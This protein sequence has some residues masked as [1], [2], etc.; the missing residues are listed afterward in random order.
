M[1]T[2]RA[3]R[4]VGIVEDL[5]GELADRRMALDGLVLER[6]ILE[7]LHDFVDLLTDLIRRGAG[8]GGD[9]GGDDES[10]EGSDHDA[11]RKHAGEG[12]NRSAIEIDLQ[13]SARQ[14]RHNETEYC[15]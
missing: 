7:H 15:E 3:L 6:G 10:E 5:L 14:P 12:C 1:R 9:R 8:D 4:R 2:E 13:L 11:M